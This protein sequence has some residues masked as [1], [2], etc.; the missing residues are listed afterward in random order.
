MTKQTFQ[1]GWTNWYQNSQRYLKKGFVQNSKEKAKAKAKGPLL[2]INTSFSALFLTACN[3]LWW[4]HLCN[5]VHLQYILVYKYS[6]MNHDCYHSQRWHDTYAKLKRIRQHLKIKSDGRNIHLFLCGW[7]I[8]TP[9]W[10]WFWLQ[11][12]IFFIRGRFAFPLFFLEF[13]AGLFSKYARH[14]QSLA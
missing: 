10:F 1:E 5:W 13:L 11:L 14:N 3:N 4:S 12:L 9:N 8:S 7:T 2:N 6:Y